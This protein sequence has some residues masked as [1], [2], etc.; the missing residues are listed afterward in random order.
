MK[1]KLKLRLG[2]LAYLCLCLTTTTLLGYGLVRYTLIIVCFQI[3]GTI[4]S[5]AASV[6]FIIFLQSRKPAEKN[7]LNRQILMHFCFKLIY[8]PYY[9]TLIFF[10]QRSNGQHQADWELILIGTL[11]SYNSTRIMLILSLVMYTLISVSRTFLLIAPAKFNSLKPKLVVQCSTII[12]VLVLAFEIAMSLFVFSPAKCDV[13]PD[14]VRMYSMAFSN[15]FSPNETNF[16]KTSLE[17]QDLKVCTTFPS[18]RIFM[19]LFLVL[20]ITRFTMAVARKYKRLKSQNTVVKPAQPNT[21]PSVGLKPQIPIK[22]CVDIK[23]SESFPSIR[24]LQY[25]AERRLSA[26]CLS[27]NTTKSPELNAPELAVV[28]T[29]IQQKD[30]TTPLDLQEMKA[31]VSFLILRTYTL[32][33]VI[34]LILSVTFLLPN[35]FISLLV[36]RADLFSLDL[37]FVPVFWILIDKDVWQFTMKN[38]RKMFLSIVLKFSR[39]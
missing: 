8:Y 20:E 18:V 11:L 35:K 29:N 12:L 13:T 27:W 36:I 26:Q 22:K 17:L 32:V 28:V 19:V 33:I 10:W 2:L 25:N 23:R 16:N 24:V 5:V 9:I 3:V 14:G 30:S 37:Y 21:A 4:V 15:E 34:I 7:I 6:A 38:C 1:T 39:E 31:Y